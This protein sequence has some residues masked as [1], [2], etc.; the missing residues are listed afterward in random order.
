[1]RYL[2]AFVV[3]IVGLVCFTGCGPDP[4]QAVMPSQYIHDEVQ[5][6]PPGDQ[7]YLWIYDLTV[8]EHHKVWISRRANLRDEKGE[9]FKFTVVDGTYVDVELTADVLADRK[10]KADDGIW[11]V[12]SRAFRVRNLTILR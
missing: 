2:L 9:T 1:M 4:N 12:S 10:F 3:V 6:V 5:N 8:D 11:I 7:A